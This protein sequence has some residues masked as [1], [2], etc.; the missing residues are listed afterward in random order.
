M[1][2]NG[3]RGR[4][5]VFDEVSS[6]PV[7]TGE[8]SDA[9]IE[10]LAVYALDP[11]LWW[12]DFLGPPYP[13]CPRCGLEAHGEDVCRPYQVEILDSIVENRETNVV[14]GH[15]VGKDFTLG[16]AVLW[17]LATRP[18]GIV[19]TTATKETQVEVILWGEVRSAYARARVPIGGTLAPQAASL[20]FG[21]DH[22]ALGMVSK[23]V[24][25]LQGFHAPGGVLVL[26]DEAAGVPEWAIQALEGCASS[27]D[28]R[29][30]KFGNPTCGHDHR[31]AKDCRLPDVPG[32]RK[33]IRVAS[34]ETCN[35]RHGEE[36]VPGLTTAGWIEAL[37]S[38]YGRESIVFRT[39]AAALFPPASAVG[40]IGYD[41]LDA[42]R[43][44]SV[45]Y[46]APENAE[47]RL[48]VDVARYGEDDT[49]I[50]AV[51]GGS[52]FVPHG[53]R[54]SG[55]DNVAVARRVAELAK[56]LGA[57]SAAIDAGGLGG[58]VYDVLRELERQGE[59]PEGFEVIP[60]DFGARAT[61]P[62]EH[63]DR[64]TELYARLRDWLRDE[65]AMDFDEGLEEELLAPSYRWNGTAIRLEPKDALKKRIG[66]SPDD[67]DALALA[68]A[69]HVGRTSGAPR[70]SVW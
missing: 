68:V 37:A 65:G 52:S 61:D 29:I 41:V 8:L 43:A 24:N 9:E 50:R 12:R 55:A 59:L 7:A 69:G 67:A 47:L 35:A 25:A 66:R 20:R 48:G 62:R 32:Q 31:F 46:E 6:R 5:V 38:K 34:W 58:G 14:T 23:D 63:A 1:T 45:G 39:R 44:R 13:W 28:S 27:D 56:K 33:T 4:Q 57:V 21:P 11:V 64:R 53:G 18:N 30:V 16:R 22:Y 10:A 70:I 40:F 60:N 17:W 36:I 3:A 51:K 2:G 54:L 15:G 49:V 42:S 26:I 19:I